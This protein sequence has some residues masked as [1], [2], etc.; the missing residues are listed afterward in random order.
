MTGVYL[1]RLCIAALLLLPAT[2]AQAAPLLDELGR[3][4]PHILEQLPPPIADFFRGTGGGVPM[5]ENAP[6][7]TQF[8][9]P[10]LGLGCIEGGN[11]VASTIAV[12]GPTEI[13]LPGA[14]AGETTFVFT[15]LGTP[16]A[17]G[18]QDMN[19]HWFNINTLQ[20][21]RTE[22]EFHGI[23]P[24]GPITLSGTAATGHGTVIAL[25]EGA[26]NQCSYLPTAA[27]FEVK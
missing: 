2:P 22:L 5:P 18:R 19:V 12:P 13:P 26:A 9:W 8:Y 21:G 25:A 27:L 24:E 3:P 20:Y 16:P 17:Q 6:H 14:K 23:N 1:K 15:A 7:F 4:A 11:A 10:S